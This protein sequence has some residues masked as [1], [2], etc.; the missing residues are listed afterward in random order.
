MPSSQA[1][2]CNQCHGSTATQM[3]LKNMGYVLK[4]AESSVCSQCHERESNPGFTSVHSRHVR[5]EGI[6]C[7][8]CH[9]FTRD[10]SPTPPPSPTNY[11]LSVTKSGTGSGTVNS[12]PAGI[13]C[14][15][16]CSQ[17]YSANTQVSL[18]ATASSGSSFAGWSG[19]SDCSDGIVTMNAS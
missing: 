5:G 15:S 6:D 1:L 19:N 10:S 13:S 4:G 2:S 14:G 7:S 18:S 11:T 9:N 3:N 12:S 17:S 8:R 16:D